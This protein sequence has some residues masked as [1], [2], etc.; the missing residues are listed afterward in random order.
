LSDHRRLT[1]TAYAVL[2]LGPKNARSA[3]LNINVACR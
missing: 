3:L 2:H 1:Y